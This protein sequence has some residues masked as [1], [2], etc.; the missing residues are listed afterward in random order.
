MS[1]FF[2]YTHPSPTEIYT[3]SLHDAL[4]IYGNLQVEYADQSREADHRVS[5]GI[6]KYLV[7]ARRPRDIEVGKRLA[8]DWSA[9]LRVRDDVLGL[10]L[11]SSLKEAVHVDLTSEIGRA[12]C[13]ERV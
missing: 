11:E 6:A 1:L 4:P 10:I 9:Y 7:Q 12:S 13:R 2:F 8:N 3:L 5:E